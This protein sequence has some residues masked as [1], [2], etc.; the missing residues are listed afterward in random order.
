MTII[1]YL[2]F[3]NISVLFVGSTNDFTVSIITKNDFKSTKKRI[4]IW[5][6]SDIKEPILYC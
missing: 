6:S 3:F 1:Q 4:N 2:C 5:N